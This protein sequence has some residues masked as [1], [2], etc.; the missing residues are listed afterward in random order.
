MAEIHVM[1]GIERRDLAGPAEGDAMR[2]LQAALDAG[3]TDVVVVGKQRDGE[4]WVSTSMGDADRAAGIM[5]RAA[6][7]LTSVRI[8]NDVVI[9][10]DE[11]AP[12]C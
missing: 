12:R 10:T 2:I 7:W 9:D 1:P 4:Q 5:L 6:N 3:I 8:D 11:G